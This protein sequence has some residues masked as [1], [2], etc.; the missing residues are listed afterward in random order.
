M[1]LRRRAT[2]PIAAVGQRLGRGL[3]GL[4]LLS[5]ACQP[6]RSASGVLVNVEATGLT[7]VQAVTLRTDDGQERRFALSGEAARS[8][9]PLSAGHLR[10]HMTNGDRVTIRYRESNDGALAVEILDG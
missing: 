8:G 10:L 9:H 4:V 3:L 6:V 2:G 1:T 7:D 5:A